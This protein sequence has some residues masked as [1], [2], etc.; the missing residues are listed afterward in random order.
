MSNQSSLS[1]RALLND[2]E[3]KRRQREGA[4][5]VL[6]LCLTLFFF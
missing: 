3:V 6:F 4:K 1:A 2:P 5:L